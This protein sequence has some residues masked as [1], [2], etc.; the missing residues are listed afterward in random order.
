MHGIQSGMQGVRR[1]AV[2]VAQQSTRS[3]AGSGDFARSMVEM[4]QHAVQAKAATRA[5]TAYNDNMGSL[6]DIKA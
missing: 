1:A 5:L 3:D 2:K 4:K 6:L